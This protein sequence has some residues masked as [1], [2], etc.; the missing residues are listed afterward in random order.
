MSIERYL[1]QS[2]VEE[3]FYEKLDHF[4]EIFV[5]RLLLTGMADKGTNLERIKMTKMP[6][7]SLKYC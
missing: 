4:H 1:F 7:F 6:E 5:L 2:D 3:F